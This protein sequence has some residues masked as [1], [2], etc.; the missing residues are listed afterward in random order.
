MSNANDLRVSF[1]VDDDDISD[2]EH[3]R[4][5]WDFVGGRP[6]VLPGEIT[7]AETGDT[8]RAPDGGVEIEIEA[9]RRRAAVSDGDGDAFAELQRQYAAAQSAREVAERTAASERQTREAYDAAIEKAR[10]RDVIERAYG[11][12]NAQLVQAQRRYADAGSN[13]DYEA[14]AIA[15]AEIASRVSQLNRYREA[16]ENLSQMAVIPQRQPEPAGD[17]FESVIANLG[18]ADKGWLRKHRGDLEGNP[19]R[20]QLLRSHA[21]IAE[22][23]EEQGGLGLQPGSPEYHQHLSEAMGYSDDEPQPRQARR[24]GGTAG[25]GRRPIAAPASRSSSSSYSKVALSEDHARMAKE[26]KMRPE[27]FA[28]FVKKSGQGQLG[29]GV[30]GGRLHASYS[31]ND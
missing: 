2:L 20:E 14:Q 19:A 24:Q 25:S 29:R 11:E 26:L 7:D 1:S 12:E 18:E 21:I 4:G 13:Y 16:H 15:A 30:T 22:A 9:P 10:H 27:D 28:Q 8:A 31:V 23:P 5:A 3:P 17:P 6:Q